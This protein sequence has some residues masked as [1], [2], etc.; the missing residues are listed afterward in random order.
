MSI[1]VPIRVERMIDF[2]LGK[3]RKQ[4]IELKPKDVVNER[5]EEK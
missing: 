3:R 1:A 4:E 5:I 2:M